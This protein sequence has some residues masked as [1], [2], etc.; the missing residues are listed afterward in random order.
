MHR[1][2]GCRGGHVAPRLEHVPVALAPRGVGDLEHDGV[3][4]P[5]VGGPAVVDGERVEQPAEGAE[6]REEMD[7][8]RRPAPEPCL[9]EVAYGGAERPV[10]AV[11]EVARAE[12]YG[13]RAARRPERQA[14]ERARQRVDVEIGEEQLR[15]EFTQ[16]GSE[17]A[18]SYRSLVDRDRRMSAGNRPHGIGRHAFGGRE[19]RGHR[20]DSSSR[21]TSSA[22]CTPSS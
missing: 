1:L 19:E 20:R 13:R 17:P 3:E 14:V 9:H 2:G 11:E 15:C 7:R 8:P 22:L 16:R 10:G 12:A 5:T 18:V 21:T 6:L 4:G